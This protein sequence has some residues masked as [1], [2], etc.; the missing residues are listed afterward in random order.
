MKLNYIEWYVVELGRNLS[1]KVPLEKRNSLL[2]ESKNHLISLTEEFQAQGMDDK[3]SQIA[4]IDRFGTPERITRQF[5]DNLNSKTGR[6]FVAILNIALFVAT[7]AIVTYL[8]LSPNELVRNGVAI[9]VLPIG[10][11]YGIYTLLRGR[12]P[13]TKW[14]LLPT[15]MSIV[16]GVPAAYFLTAYTNNGGFLSHVIL[17]STLR[18]QTQGFRSEVQANEQ[19]LKPYMDSYRVALGSPKYKDGLKAG[20]TF[21]VS[22]YT[23]VRGS[24]GLYVIFDN[25]QKPTMFV[26]KDPNKI[27]LEGDD[28]SIGKF[29]AG[30]PEVMAGPLSGTNF[31]SYFQERLDSKRRSQ[32]MNESALNQLE[33]ALNM[34]LFERFK[35]FS[36]RVASATLLFG[37]PAAWIASWIAFAIRNL[38][39]LPNRRFRLA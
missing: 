15:T 38:F 29:K 2:H 24:K 21:S 39:R 32:A 14:L 26:A 12:R 18:E 1:E 36:F 13:S 22:S 37:L 23:C 20:E 9:T 33:T 25:P 6:A 30:K 31:R 16:I 19:F 27:N 11:T 4:A 34:S 35:L 17:Y 3:E 5:L 8:V 28:F 10:A 7:C